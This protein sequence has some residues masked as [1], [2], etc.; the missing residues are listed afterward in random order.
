[1]TPNIEQLAG[2]QGVRAET[3]FEPL[4]NTYWL[5][6]LQHFS[7]PCSAL[8]SEMRTLLRWGLARQSVKETEK[9][10]SRRT[11]V[12]EADKPTCYTGLL[13]VIKKLTL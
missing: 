12:L 2:W 13:C 3:R 10:L 9:V 7:E 1:M 4:P 8:I 6:D 5:C 11:Y